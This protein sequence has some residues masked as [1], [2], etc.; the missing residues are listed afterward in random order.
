MMRNTKRKPNIILTFTVAC[1]LF[2]TACTEHFLEGN[3]YTFTGETVGSFLEQHEDIYG[4]FIYILQRSGEFSLMKAYGEY[5]CFAPTNEAIERFLFEQDSIWR[6]SLKPESKR[7]RWTG[8]TSPVLEEL[9]DSMCRVISRTHIIDTKLLT[10]DLDGSDVLRYKNLNDRF[11]T[12][13]YDVNE[14]LHSQLFINGALM[15]VSD[16]E[17]ENG[18]IHTMADVVNPS[19][20][21]VP[22]QIADIPFLSLFSEALKVT[23]WDGRMQEYEDLSY[24]Q[25]TVKH[26]VHR[27][28][29]YTAFCEPDEVYASLG[30]NTVDELSAKCREWYPEATSTDPTSPDNALNKFIAYHILDRK[31]LY[32]RA[33]CYDI[34][35]FQFGSCLYDSEVMS[36][37]KSDRTEFYET[38]Q[39]TLIKMTRPLSINAYGHELLLNYS[40]TLIG[41]IDKYN[42]PAGKRGA[43]FNVHVFD[44]VVVKDNADRYPGYNQDALNGTILIIDHP[45]IYDEDIMVGQVLNEPIRFDASAILPELTTNNIRWGD[46][47]TFTL[48]GYFNYTEI[49]VDYSPRLKVYSEDPKFRYLG[50]FNSSCSYQGDAMNFECWGDIALRIPHVPAGTYELRVA[51]SSYTDRGTLQFYVDNIVTGIPVDLALTAENPI[52]GWTKDE[53]TDDNGVANDKQM[54]N[55]GY[56]KGLTTQL[57]NNGTATGRNSPQCLRLVLTTKYFGTGDHWVRMKSV[58]DHGGNMLDYFE[59]API[60]WLRDEG[61]SLDEKRR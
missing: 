43:I 18:V 31:L 19:A 49:P 23:G 39:G 24:T 58:I 21:M 34:A 52:V 14:E 53:Y 51:Y 7:V 17:V 40:K 41:S 3:L 6:E 36:V 11:L 13:S 2:M 15:M 5:T 9:S 38:M 47:P 54:K 56:L 61:I 55:R 42:C 8:V 1:T 35:K 44:P 29:G 20:N 25:P 57:V 27:Y 48:G 50:E 12:V 59:L 26:P 28:I 46:N 32:S 22:A 4:D 45:L 10:M 30:I 37:A 16:E 60:G 33:V